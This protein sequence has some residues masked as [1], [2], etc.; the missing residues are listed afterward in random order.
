MQTQPS[1]DFVDDEKLGIV[2][3]KQTRDENKLC[4]RPTG[5]LATIAT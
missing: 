4:L 2:N 1:P 5:I 3:Q